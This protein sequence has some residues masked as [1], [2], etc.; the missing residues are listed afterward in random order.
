MGPLV[1]IGKAP[2]RKQ[3]SR[4]RTVIFSVLLSQ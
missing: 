4:N 2:L 3:R 1:F